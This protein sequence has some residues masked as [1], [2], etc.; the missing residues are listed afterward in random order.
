MR[1]LG[2]RDR[3]QSTTARVNSPNDVV[4]ASNGSIWFIDPTYGVRSW[5][6]GSTATS[7]RKCT[8]PVRSRRSSTIFRAAERHPAFGD[9]WMSLGWGD[10]KEDGVR[11]YAPDGTLPGKISPRP[12]PT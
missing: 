6:E 7:S 5:Y 3:R 2:E 12:L 8:R 9:V 1:R 11:C 4:V 10:P